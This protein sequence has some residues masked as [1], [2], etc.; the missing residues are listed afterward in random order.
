MGACILT[1]EY[2]T[3]FLKMQALLKINFLRRNVNSY[4]H[5]ERSEESKDSVTVS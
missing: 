1:F 5:S 4:C 3:F 2:T